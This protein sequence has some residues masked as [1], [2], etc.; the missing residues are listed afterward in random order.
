MEKVPSSE[1]DAQRKLP[2]AV[3]AAIGAAGAGDP[4]EGVAV[5]L[6]RGSRDSAGANECVAIEEEVGG[7]VGDVAVGHGIG[8]LRAARRGVGARRIAAAHGGGQVGT[9]LEQENAAGVPA[10]AD[11]IGNRV[12]AIAESA[13]L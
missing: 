10:A 6:V 1:L 3:A 7:G 9:G 12:P 11:C 13:S 8:A 2:D 4:A 5:E